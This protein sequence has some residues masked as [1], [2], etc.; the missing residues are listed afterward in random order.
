MGQKLLSMVLLAAAM[1]LG[2]SPGVGQ[3]AQAQ[4]SPDPMPPNEGTRHLGWAPRSQPAMVLAERQPARRHLSAAELPSGVRHRVPQD[5]ATIQAA[6]NSCADGDTVLVS[7][8]TYTENI[9]YCGKAIVVASLYLVDQDTSHIAKTIINGNPFAGDSTSVVYFIDGED[10]TSVLCGFTITGGTGTRYLYNGTGGTA[11]IRVGGGVFCNSSGA[12]IVRNVITRNRVIEATV[13]GGGLFARGTPSI[14]PSLILDG[15]RF[16]DNYLRGESATGWA[17][18]GGAGIGNASARVVGNVFERDTILGAGSAVG[19]GM[20]IYTDPPVLLIEGRIQGNIFRSNIVSATISGGVGAGLIAYRTGGLTISEN[21][22]ED[23]V[24]TSETGW[25]EGGGLCVDDQLITGYGRKLI[26][27]NRFLSNTVDC[28][29][30]NAGGGIVLYRTLATLGG[31]Y[32]AN[33]TVIQPGGLGGGG[34]SIQNSSFRVEN[35]IIS[36]NSSVASGGGVTVNGAP[37]IGTEQLIVN[38]TFVDNHSP[39]LGSALGIRYAPN[40]L[41]FNTIF[42]DDTAAGGGE[43]SL[44][45]TIKGV[46]YCDVKGAYPGTGNI[47]QD[48]AF[49]S[50]D[51]LSFHLQVSSPCIGRG[52]DSIQVAGLWYYAPNCDYDGNPRHRPA[53]PQPS[54]IGAQEEQVTTDVL[55]GRTARPTQFALEQNY[56]NPFNPVTNIQFTIVNRQLT[57]VKVYD[58]LGSEVATL[59]NEVKEPGTYTV[60][61]DG[62]GLASGVYFYRIQ[63]G[64]LA[65][66]KKLVILK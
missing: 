23:N 28:A 44:S 61:L 42:W 27:N 52:K 35:N 21:L 55:D 4:S 56:P 6:I 3:T 43:I 7:E 22:F 14:R 36:G 59:V 53:G 41:V 48:P 26:L 57:I 66:T 64:D 65:Q 60:H 18:S 40:L 63:A 9:R 20:S 38:N 32:F 49:I 31:N 10:T 62:S 39:A 33:N 29:A 37:Q 11:W 16:T 58:V 54:D 25:A 34:V 51:T 17:W 13:E 45:G 2:V 30:G 15:N 19:G 46:S 12:R 1:V 8:G 5:F 50:G 24:G 47:N